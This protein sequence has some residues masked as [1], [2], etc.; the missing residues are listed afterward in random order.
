MISDQ[1]LQ[2]IADDIVFVFQCVLCMDEVG[3]NDKVGK[4]TLLYSNLYN[5]LYAK[6]DSPFIDIVVNSYIEYIE[7]GRKKY[8]K[9]YTKKVPIDVLRK[10]AKRKGI[11]TDNS[12]LYAIQQSIYLY[13]IKPRPIME[14]VWREVDNNIDEIFSVLYDEII[15]ELNIFFNQ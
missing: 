8:T 10:W 14:Y 6:V 5:D 7:R 2:H 15:K 9:K 11:P 3:M 1:I 13:G 12:T 4:N